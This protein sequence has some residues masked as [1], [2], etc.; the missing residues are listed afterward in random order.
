MFEL[1]RREPDG[2]YTTIRIY[3]DDHVVEAFLYAEDI[4]RQKVTAT[5]RE[6]ARRAG[7]EPKLNAIIERSRMQHATTEEDVRIAADKIIDM[8]KEDV[9][10]TDLA[11]ANTI[12]YKQRARSMYVIRRIG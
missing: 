8:A 7:L 5:F 6:Q 12:L 3:E 2:S 9:G 1:A 10:L 4:E 11:L